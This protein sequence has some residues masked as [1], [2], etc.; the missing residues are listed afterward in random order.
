MAKTYF[1]VELEDGSIYGGPKTGR[2]IDAYEGYCGAKGEP[3]QHHATRGAIYFAWF[4][5]RFTHALSFDE[6]MDKAIDWWPSDAEGNRIGR[7][8]AEAAE[9]LESTP[10]QPVAEGV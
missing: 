1:T 9:A 3:I 6:F 8:E 10:T 5:S 2:V 7:A 4:A